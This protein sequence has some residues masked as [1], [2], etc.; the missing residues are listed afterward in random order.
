MSMITPARMSPLD[1]AH[2][3]LLQRYWNAANY[4]TIGQIY[5]KARSAPT[6]YL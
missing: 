6:R 5:L 1:Q 2:L 3:E 4:L